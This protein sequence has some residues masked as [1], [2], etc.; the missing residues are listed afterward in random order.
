M[1]VQLATYAGAQRGMVRAK[2]QHELEDNECWTLIDAFL[3]QDGFIT[4]RAGLA[5]AAGSVS[6]AL[7]LGIAGTMSPAGVWAA[8]QITKR[9]LDNQ[10]RID[11]FKNTTISEGIADTNK[12]LN[13]G[14]EVD[15]SKWSQA[16]SGTVT[17]TRD[18]GTFRSGVA[19]Q[20]MVTDGTFSGQGANYNDSNNGA[21]VYAGDT[22]TASGYFLQVAG[23]MSVRVTIEF[24][25]AAD[26]S[27]V[28][29]NSSTTVLGAN[30]WT[31]VSVT[32]TAPAGTV[33]AYVRFINANATVVTFFIDD[34][35]LELAGS[36]PLFDSKDAL[37]GGCLIGMSDG[38]GT[39]Q[40]TQQTLV[41]YRG[42]STG[43]PS[44]GTYAV[45]GAVAVG[46]TTI[47][48][49]ANGP[50]WVPGHFVFGTTTNDLIGVVKSVSGNV[51]TLVAPAL[52]AE[53]TSV[54]GS[55]W[56]GL[57]R[58]VSK[59]RIT[60]AAAATTVNGGETLFRANGLNSGTWDIFTTEYNFVGTVASVASDAQLTL[61]SGAAIALLNSDYIAIKRGAG[62]VATNEVFGW[63]NASYAGHQFYA[64][65]NVVTFSDDD[66]FEA[67]DVDHDTIVV[68]EDNVSALIP[69]SQGL[70]IC[71]ETEAH[72]LLG[73]VGTTPDRWRAD[74]IHD[75]GC[76]SPMTARIYK[77]GA[78]WAGRRGVWY[79]NGDDPV[80]LAAALGDRYQA[81]VETL[82]VG[83]TLR[84]V[85]SH[86]HYLLHVE[87]TTQTDIRTYDTANYATGT[88]LTTFTICIKLDDG[89]VSILR[90][91]GVRGMAEPPPAV[92]SETYFSMTHL[93]SGTRT[94]RVFP[95]RDLFQENNSVGTDSFLCDGETGAAGSYPSFELET[96]KYDIG[97]P[98]LLKLFKM[99]LLHYDL[100]GTVNSGA[101]V[102]NETADHLRFA[103]VK[104]LG[105]VGALSAKKFFLDPVGQS[106]QD[107]RLKFMKRSQHLS[108][109]MW[110]GT[111]TITRLQLG[112]WAI[113]F[114]P[115][116]PGRV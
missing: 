25:D 77:G 1:S 37:G 55:A 115:K 15:L 103:T 97:N 93:L 14:F 48:L 98:Q 16:G 31:Q 36:G 20:K 34:T 40:A 78:I 84:G 67:V 42:A 2:S 114:K 33:K 53:A 60:V 105:K 65:G 12:I 50:H 85:V 4:R 90:N 69:A 116:R 100:W 24:K 94:A 22:V 29:N 72:V 101:A 83:T 11:G 46:N 75:D 35:K 64:T 110:Q 13:P 102:T 47:T 49:T 66:H 63:L 89:A 61:A 106:W 19:S 111:T 21:V 80:N 45:S 81:I 43:A 10:L 88:A 39:P 54:Y 62:Y 6:G 44:A 23:G 28:I 57:Q 51:L 79:W 82:G 71:T 112:A 17:R 41:I 26:N 108:I 52:R 32:A 91:V 27:L 8:A 58:R 5:T 74:R 18:T 113:G 70:V 95:A 7:A 9:V 56:R 3:N 73:A 87:S 38:L 109:R 30:T 99:L 96:K 104:G 86:G 92:S 76:I 59:G 107:K 68:S